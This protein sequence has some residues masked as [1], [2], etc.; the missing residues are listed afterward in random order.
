MR[1]LQSPDLKPTEQLWDVGK[2]EIPIINMKPVYQQKLY[3]D[4]VLRRCY[5]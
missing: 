4:I 1:L 5:S 2:Q 3:D